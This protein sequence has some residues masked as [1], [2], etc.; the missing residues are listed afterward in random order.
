MMALGNNRGSALIDDLTTMEAHNQGRSL[1]LSSGGSD[2]RALQFFAQLQRD[3]RT[4]AADA[5]PADSVMAT[6]S[7]WASA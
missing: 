5:T 1:G 6:R 3:G 2:H 4:E 7:D